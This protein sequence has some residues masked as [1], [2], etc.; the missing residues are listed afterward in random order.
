MQSSTAVLGWGDDVAS[1]PRHPNDVAC[2]PHHLLTRFDKSSGLWYTS[3][4]WPYAGCARSTYFYSTVIWLTTTVHSGSF[5]GRLLFPRSELPISRTF[6]PPKVWEMSST[7]R[8]IM[9]MLAQRVQQASSWHALVIQWGLWRSL[10]PWEQKGILIPRP[11]I[12]PWR[13]TCIGRSRN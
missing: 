2:M 13:C 3:S 12:E 9:L 10:L 11:S 6:G 4:V 5:L 8:S 1:M 7:R